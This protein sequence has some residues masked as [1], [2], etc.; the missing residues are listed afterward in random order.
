MFIYLLFFMPKMSHLRHQH[1]LRLQRFHL[2]RHPFYQHLYSHY[3]Y[4]YLQLEDSII[5]Q[6]VPDLDLQLQLQVVLVLLVVD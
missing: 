4:C 6:L 5:R 2:P 3:Y 1:L